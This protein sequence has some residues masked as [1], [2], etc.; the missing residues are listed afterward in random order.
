MAST[1]PKTNF[2]ASNGL[3]YTQ[4]NALEE[5]VRML[6]GGDATLPLSTDAATGKALAKRDADGDIAFRDVTAR[7]VTAS[8]KFAG[9]HSSTIPDEVIHCHGLT[10]G[11]NLLARDTNSYDLPDSWGLLSSYRTLYSGILRVKFAL[12]G[13]PGYVAYGRIY[14]NGIAYGTIRSWDEF[15]AKLFSE[16]L[17][18]DDGDVIQAYG[19]CAPSGNLLLHSFGIYANAVPVVY[20]FF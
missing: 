16:D 17:S 5:N 1:A 18:F 20:G 8:G 9:L 7:D 6:Q 14:K 15:S 19:Y 2:I 4:L 12:V 10:A 3:T 13:Y 11:E